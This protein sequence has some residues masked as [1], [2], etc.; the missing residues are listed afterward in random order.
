VASFEINSLL[1]GKPFLFFLGYKLETLHTLMFLFSFLAHLIIILATLLLCRFQPLKAHGVTP[2]L[3]ALF[4]T[5]QLLI[6]LL[7]FTDLETF[8]QL[9][10]YLPLINQPI[11]TSL[12]IL[13]PL[14]HA[15]F[16]VIVLISQ[17]KSLFANAQ[18]MF[19]KKII[20][21]ILYGMKILSHP[22]VHLSLVLISLLICF[23]VSFIFLVENNF[24]MCLFG[25][26]KNFIQLFRR[27]QFFVLIAFVPLTI[28]DLLLIFWGSVVEI[29]NKSL[30]WLKVVF[31]P[32]Y[33]IRYAWKADL[34]YFRIQYYFFGLLTILPLNI[35]VFLTRDSYI[36]LKRENRLKALPILDSFY[37]F[38]IVF[39][40]TGFPL[41][42]TIITALK[43]IVV[44]KI[45]KKKVSASEFDNFFVDQTKYNLLKEFAE[46]EMSIENVE[47]YKD[48]LNYQK[49]T[50]IKKRIEFAKRLNQTYFNG[51]SSP[52]E[53]NLPGSAL[54]KYASN[55][56]AETFEKGNLFNEISDK[57][58]ENIS[59]TYSRLIISSEY[60]NYLAKSKYMNE[61]VG[62]GDFL[63][64]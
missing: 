60:T 4:S 33:S 30:Q 13:F 35:I 38:S 63:L 49:L 36:K 3:F 57:I 64:Q 52:L 21:F 17:S 24:V 42:I 62:E 14:N 7:Y 9:R 10:C 58:V 25:N 34:F 46:K 22:I 31:F 12:L 55:Y 18:T 48:I 40:Q 6:C 19:K 5:V 39:M 16:I 61:I 44:K 29:K 59:D 41:I 56:A 1:D 23:F 20:T 51:I 26:D 53:V 50:T 43:W 2:S 11:N 37:D 54:S 32:I 8:S 45:Q 28:I 47:C 15:R 27:I